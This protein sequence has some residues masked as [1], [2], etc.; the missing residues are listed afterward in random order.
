MNRG[1]VEIKDPNVI[2]DLRNIL[3]SSNLEKDNVP[4]IFDVNTLAHYKMMHCPIFSL[5]SIC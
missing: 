3:P 2:S 1:L 5:L 4:M